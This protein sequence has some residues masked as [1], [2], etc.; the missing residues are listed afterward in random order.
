MI[1]SPQ[2]LYNL[3]PTSTSREKSPIFLYG[4]PF[5]PRQPA[6]P[7]A[8]SLS[9]TRI[10]SPFSSDRRYQ[11]LFLQALKIH[12]NRSKRLVKKGDLLAIGLNIDHMHRLDAQ[13]EYI[14]SEDEV[15]SQHE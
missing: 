3:C 7:N 13:L 12:L 10:S 4:S 5:G 6:I 9:L 1:G 14:D 2:L 15:K 11:S 8:G